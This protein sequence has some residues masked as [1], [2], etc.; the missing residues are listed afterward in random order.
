MAGQNHEEMS[1]S[2]RALLK[3]VAA[4]G[5]FAVPL[6]ASF[7]MD[8]ASA[9]T[10]AGAFGSS[11][12]SIIA[13]NMT[14]SNMTSFPTSAFYAELVQ[15]GTT[16][17]VAGLAGF[18]FVRDGNELF[19]EMIVKG[20]LSDFRVFGPYGF[21]LFEDRTSAKLGAI[22]GSALNCGENSLATLY[23]DFAAGGSTIEVVAN[24]TVLEGTIVGLG[25]NAAARS[26]FHFG[27][28]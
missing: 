4:G 6:I 2:R 16:G 19:Y 17:P 11:N 9:Q 20:T 10:R 22:P 1:P 27:Q 13:S 3:A 25:A 7:S 5:A 8:T 14:C 26:S 24:G 21:P 12:Q 18:E 15:Y 23:S 28:S